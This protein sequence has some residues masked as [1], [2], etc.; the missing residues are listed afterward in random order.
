MDI[1]V[2]NNNEDT[3]TEFRRTAFEYGTGRSWMILCDMHSDMGGDGDCAEASW[4]RPCIWSLRIDIF[5]LVVPPEGA[6]QVGLL[7]GGS[8]LRLQMRQLGSQKQNGGIVCLGSNHVR[9]RHRA[10]FLY[11]FGGAYKDD[12]PSRAQRGRVFTWLVSTPKLE[13]NGDARLLPIEPPIAL[14]RTD[15]VL[16]CIDED[17][18]YCVDPFRNG[19]IHNIAHTLGPSVGR[20]LKALLREAENPISPCTGVQHATVCIPKLADTLADESM[21]HSCCCASLREEF[22]WF[23]QLLGSNGF[24]KLVSDLIISTQYG[25]QPDRK[26]I[27]GRV[28][29][30]HDLV[31][32]VLRDGAR[33]AH[34]NVCVSPK[35]TGGH[36]HSV[37][38]RVFRD[39]WPTE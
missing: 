15:N 17:F 24:H 3:V 14:R 10:L 37:L 2:V 28:N 4:V 30:L 8:A 39:V 33:L 31:H 11:I 18:A 16:F 20:R 6:K 36:V 35:W 1:S 9:R 27:T 12:A 21:L 26:L 29:I 7:P 23:D 32:R 38:R 5:W 13:N 25:Q 19:T 34:L 22:M